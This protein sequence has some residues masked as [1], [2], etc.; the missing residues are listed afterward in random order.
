MTSKIKEKMKRG[1]VAVAVNLSGR[2]PDI[3]EHLA[4]LGAD[5]AFID[6]ERTGIGLDAATDLIRASRAA[7]L[8]CV[9]RSWSRSPE[10]LVRYLDRKA[11]GIVVPHV[12]SAAEAASIVE[13]VR[14]ACGGAAA[15]KLVVVQIE[16]QAAVKVVDA[17]AAVPGVD[18]FL[19]GPND[20]S[21]EMTGTRGARTPEVNQ[22]IE[23]VAARLRH[24][25]RAFG[26]PAR[27]NEIA[28]FRALGATFLYYPV[29]WLLE[30]GLEELK[31][32]TAA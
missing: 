20:L 13:L 3:V 24:A 6:C 12:E 23:H 1:E 29:E 11:D 15:E 19:V 27:L 18:V 21:Y 26:M 28:A 4:R 22:A 10:V 30:R 8:P 5:L 25:G 2:N 31:R 17:M 9:V 7:G 16:T 32:A 14:Y